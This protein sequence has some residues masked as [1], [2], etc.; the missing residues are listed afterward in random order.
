M[1]KENG[2]TRELLKRFSEF[3]DLY[4]KVNEKVNPCTTGLG[5]PNS[6]PCAR[7]SDLVI[8]REPRTLEGYPQAAEKVLQGL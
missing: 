7:A 1:V 3:I 4:E 5:N 6:P 8:L 2:E